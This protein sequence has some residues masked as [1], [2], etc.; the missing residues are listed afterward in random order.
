MAPPAFMT[1][2][3][4]VSTL[5]VV[6]AACLMILVI[7]PLTVVLL[8]LNFLSSKLRDN[9]GD[10]V[11]TGCGGNSKD[12]KVELSYSTLSLPPTV[13]AMPPPDG[14]LA[15]FAVAGCKGTAAGRLGSVVLFAV[16]LAGVLC[17]KWLR[18]EVP[19]VATAVLLT[20]AGLT[21]AGLLGLVAATTLPLVCI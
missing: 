19:A 5:L 1:V 11:A 15:P 16:A 3:I 12:N 14:T 6:L 4:V 7:S 9:N 20:A 2:S 13:F 10:S 21:V 17:S 8:A 18:F